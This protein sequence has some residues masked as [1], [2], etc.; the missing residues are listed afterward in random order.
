MTTWTNSSFTADWSSLFAA[1]MSKQLLGEKLEAEWP[2]E[3]LFTIQ[4]RR[5]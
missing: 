1:T 4:V 3:I 5:D 2:W